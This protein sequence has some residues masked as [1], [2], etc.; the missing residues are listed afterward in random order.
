WFE[1]AVDDFLTIWQSPRARMAF[2]AAARNIYLDEPEGERGFWTRLEHME[3]PAFYIF[4][5][6]DLLITH[7]FAKKV[8]TALPNTCVEV[9]NHCGHV[10]QI[11]Y[12]DRTAR[13]LLGFFERTQS[14]RSAVSA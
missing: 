3:T 12:P 11:E 5:K 1:A 7:H 9:W 14:R 6:Q 13:A 8:R 2:S 4:G 10:P